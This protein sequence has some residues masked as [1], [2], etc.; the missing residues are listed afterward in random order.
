MTRGA[1][2]LAL[3]AAVCGCRG[4]ARPEAKPEGSAAAAAVQNEG[5]VEIVPGPNE[6]SVKA[7][8]QAEVTRART[9]H[10]QLVVYVGAHWC[11]PCMRFH[12]AA[13]AGKLDA[14]YPR[15]TLLEFDLDRDRERLAEAGYVSRMIPLFMLPNA[16]G[17]ASGE[18]IEGSIKG[19]AAVDEIAPRL[20]A[21]LAKA[22]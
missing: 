14:R 15:L 17:S 18:H 10:R 12:Q 7:A 11:E 4:E 5:K 19:D 21:L 13:A 20:D 9:R 1:A 22:R 2:A 6:G 16:D 3:A 8:V